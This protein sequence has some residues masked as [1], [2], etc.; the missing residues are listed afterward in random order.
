MRVQHVASWAARIALAAGFLSAVADRF[1]LWGAPGATN[2]SWGDWRHFV[3]AVAVLNGFAP[4]T[5]VPV[6][7]IAATLAESTLGVMLLIGYRL[8][9]TAYGA[10]ALLTIFGIAMTFS[11]SVKAPLDYSVFSAAGA[12]FL[13]GSHTSGAAFEN[14]LSKTEVPGKP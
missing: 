13:V 5:L 10:A 6:I 9:W 2:V 3:E 4:K 1:G 8:R 12:A 11:S 14:S 7:A